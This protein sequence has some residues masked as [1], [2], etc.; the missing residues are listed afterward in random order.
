MFK[1]DQIRSIH[2]E[3]SSFCNA[4]C[5]HCPRNDSG[6][7]NVSDY[8]ERNLTLHDV[9]SII[10]VELLKNLDNI[11]YNGNLGDMIMNPE[12][13]EI[14][15]WFRDINP[16][17]KI[18]ANTNGGARD[19]KFWR[20]MASLDVEIRFGIDGLADTHH[21]Y[22]QNTVFDQV[23][24]NAQIFIEAGGNAVWKMIKFKHNQH[25]IELCQDMARNLG[26]K[27]FQVV[28]MNRG[29]VHAYDKHGNYS[30][31]IE[32]Y[33]APRDY[34][35]MRDTRKEHTKK[36]FPLQLSQASIHELIQCM[37]DLK[38]EIYINSLGEIYPCCFLGHNPRTLDPIRLQ[39]VGILQMS[40][41]LAPEEIKINA[42][43]HGLEECLEWFSKIKETWDIP[44]FNQGRLLICDQ[45]C[46]KNPSITGGKIK[47]YDLFVDT[48]DI[49]EL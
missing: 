40:D 39:N 27:E 20:S 24:K 12:I 43:E 15:Q 36:Y 3:P 47:G 30:H 41:L 2:L 49:I 48:T 38:K 33:D 17:V 23:V 42:L 10:S 18:Q 34:E 9:Q 31:T 21:L 22:R 29:M 32:E 44:S 46:G 16:K 26:F 8:K 28:N 7:E 37:S 19:A 11:L 1:L 13:V 6:V 14:T 35:T 4:R 45:T 25:Q 5:P